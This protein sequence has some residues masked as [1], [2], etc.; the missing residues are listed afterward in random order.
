MTV[1]ITCLIIKGT[2]VSW[3][4]PNLNR[5]LSKEGR[6]EQENSFRYIF[7][8]AQVIYVQCKVVQC[9]TARCHRG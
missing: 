7:A 8:K 6:K 4:N 5:M 1:A 3:P 2:Y 9:L